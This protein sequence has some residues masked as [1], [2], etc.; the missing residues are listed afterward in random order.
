M[1]KMKMMKRNSVSLIILLVMLIALTSCKKVIIDNHPQGIML[2]NIYQDL[3]AAREVAARGVSLDEFPDVVFKCNIDFTA[4]DELIEE[5]GKQG[6]PMS[7]YAYD[8]N[9][10]GYRELCVNCAYGSGWI[11][12]RV[13]IYDYKNIKVLLEINDRE[14]YSYYLQQNEEGIYVVETY[15]L[16][17]A[18]KTRIGN[19]VYEKGNLSVQWENVS[20]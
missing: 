17:P 12:D 4:N 18:H 15:I 9:Y 14:N 2:W 19:F 8:L 1:H 16:N 11:D 3:D 20:E 7:F 6:Y 10:D 5:I 13:V